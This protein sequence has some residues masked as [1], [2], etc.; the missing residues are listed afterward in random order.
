MTA[1][2]AVVMVHV[3]VQENV[4]HKICS[5]LLALEKINRTRLVPIGAV[6]VVN[7]STYLNFAFTQCILYY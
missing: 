6:Q 2:K 1:A 7:A 4:S 3:I 5:L